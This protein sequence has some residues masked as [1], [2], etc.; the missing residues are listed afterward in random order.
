MIGLL[1][2]LVLFCFGCPQQQPARTVVNVVENDEVDGDPLPPPPPHIS[3]G[4]VPSTPPDELARFYLL[5]RERLP[6]IEPDQRLVDAAEEILSLIEDNSA[7]PTRHQRNRAALHAGIAEPLSIMLVLRGTSENIS[8]LESQLQASL[9]QR[10]S[11]IGCERIGIARTES[12]HQV[13][14]V[15]LAMAS[16][17]TLEPVPLVRAAGQPLSLTGRVDPPSERIEILVASPEGQVSS[18]YHARAGDFSTS[19]EPEMVGPHRFEIIADIEGSPTVLALFPVCFGCRQPLLSLEAPEGQTRDAESAR[20]RLR[21]LINQTR[22]STGV[23]PLLM[24]AELCQVAQDYADQL[25]ADG[26]FSHRGDDQDGPGER[27][28]RAGLQSDVVLENI[29]LA[30]TAELGFLSV[31]ESPAHLRAILDARTTHIGVGVAA[32][33]DGDLRI[34]I[35]M[36]HFAPPLDAQHA[37]AELIDGIGEARRREGV[38]PLE[39]VPELSAT[40]LTVA[41]LVASAI[42]NGQPQSEALQAARASL[43]EI[44]SVATQAAFM[45]LRSLDEIQRAAPIIAEETRRIGIA[46]VPLMLDSSRYFVVVLIDRGE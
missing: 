10:C 41:N 16:R 25:V 26:R 39:V 38:T 20:E 28:A 30:A 14:L 32:G 9:A 35:N 29:A 13:T 45:N 21:S 8:Q 6:D 5:A 37:T 22:E 17:L 15:V 19:F 31:L 44:R 43:L 18:L 7:S 46:A 12:E 27:V 42:R 24:Q 2:I 11:L 23:A 33:D 4:H 3:A 1:L 40:A 36:A 34:V